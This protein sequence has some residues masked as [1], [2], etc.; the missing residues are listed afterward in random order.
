MNMKNKGQIAIGAAILIAIT[1]IV[2]VI[3][4]TASA[5]NLGG[6]LNTQS[7]VN[8]SFASVA[9]GSYITLIGVE[10]LGT[11][12]A[13]NA[14]AGNGTVIDS[15]NFTITNR[16]VVN[17]VLV[18]R[19]QITSPRFA[20][21]NTTTWNLS[22]SYEP[23]TYIDDS[24]GRSVAGIILVLMALALVVVGLSPAL[25]EEIFN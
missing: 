21:G 9:N 12:T 6:A 18:S 23:A 5:Q 20:L 17:G 19:L 13:H 4:F 7:L 2:G 11:V 15:G 22:Y 10:V 8:G 3:L 1:L 14:T 24:A 16:E 25:R